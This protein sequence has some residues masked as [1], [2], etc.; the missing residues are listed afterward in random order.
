MSSFPEHDH[1]LNELSAYVD[2][3]LW[4]LL[5]EFKKHTGLPPHSWLVQRRIQKAKQLL[6]QGVRITEVAQLTGFSDQSHLNRHFKS[7]IGVTP[8]QYLLNY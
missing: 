3:S 5:R 7:A 6:K 1:S 2:T 8:R 4:H